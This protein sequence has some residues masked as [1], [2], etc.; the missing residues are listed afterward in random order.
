M[1]ERQ[2]SCPAGVKP[3]V[4]SLALN[5][6]TLPGMALVTLSTTRPNMGLTLLGLALPGRQPSSAM[7]LHFC[8][9]NPQDRDRGLGNRA[10]A[11]SWLEPLALQDALSTAIVAPSMGYGGTCEHSQRPPN[12]SKQVKTLPSFGA[13]AI[14]QQGSICLACGQPWFDPCVPYVSEPCQK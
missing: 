4:P 7:T 13:G 3:W 10:L 2:N 6:L 5:G 1:A 8:Y 12:S 14:A 9:D 11:L